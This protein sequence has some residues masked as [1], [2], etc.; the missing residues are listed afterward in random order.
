M[1][2]F[3]RGE[4]KQGECLAYLLIPAGGGG[5]AGGPWCTSCRAP[6]TEEQRSA[7]VHFN[8]DPHGHKGFTGLYHAECS[9]PFASMA[10]IINSNWFGRF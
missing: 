3:A 6:I 2:R 7:R 9:K 5:G 4:S 10:R 8:H 1:P